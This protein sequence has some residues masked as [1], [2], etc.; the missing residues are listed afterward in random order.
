M[1]KP[2]SAKR[3][4]LTACVLSAIALPAA[5]YACGAVKLAIE[6][7]GPSSARPGDT[8]TY[9]FKVS[10]KLSGT[11]VN[12]FINDD[13]H[14][15]LEYVSSQITGA[16]TR[17]HCEMYNSG[18]T[19][20]LFRCYLGNMGSGHKNVTVTASFKIP[21]TL[22]CVTIKNKA[23]VTAIE[24]V[25]TSNEISTAIECGQPTLSIQKSGQ[26]VITRGDTIS[27]TLNISNTGNANAQ[28]VT[29][30]DPIPSGVTFVSASTDAFSSCST[31]SPNVVCNLGTLAPNQSR[32]I[33][34]I[35]STSDVGACTPTTVI[36]QAR[37]SGSN[38]NTP[39]TAPVTVHSNTVTTQVNCREIPKGCIDVVKQALDSNSNPVT[40]IPSFT[41]T[42]DGSRT[43]S[44]NQTGNLRFNDVTPGT[45]TVTETPLS[46]WQQQSVNPLNGTVNV[47]SGTQCAQVIFQNKQ[48][49]PPV[50]CI[51]VIK[52]VFDANGTQ[53]TNVP[54]FTFTLDGTTTGV[55]DGNGNLR[56]NNVTPALHTVTETLPAGWTQEIVLP[57]QGKVNVQSG[58]QCAQVIFRNKQTPPQTGCIEVRKHAYDPQEV[59]ITAV[60]AFT[61]TLDGTR[62]GA[63]NASGILTFNNVSV[64]QHTVSE[65]VLP[66][67]MIAG[68]TPANGQVTVQA[69]S[70][71]AIVD[72]INKQL[73]AQTGCIEITKSAKDANDNSI[74]SVPPFVF[75]LDGT[76]TATNDTT[77]RTRFDNVSVGS[78]SVI[79]ALPAGWTLQSVTPA[80]GAVTVAAG[81]QCAQVSFVNKQVPAQTG[82]IEITKQAVSANGNN[83]TPIPAFTFK[84]DNNATVTSAADGRARFNSVSVGSHVV[85]EVNL[86]GW[87]LETV[88]PANGQVNVQ[89][90]NNCAQV[91]FR[92]R[93]SAQ[94]VDFSISKTDNET[95]VEPG[96]E[97]TYEITVRNNGS[98]AVSNVTVTDELPDEVDFISASQNGQRNSRTIT[99]NGLTFAAFETKILSVNVE[100]DEDADCDTIRNRATVFDKSATDETDIE[101]CDDDE[102]AEIEITKESSTSEV[103]A[104]GIIEYTV[105]LKNTGEGELE[106]IEVTDHLP[107]GVIVIDDGDA[108]EHDD[109]M[110]MWE[111]DSLDED[112]TWTVTYRVNV[113]VNIQPGSLLRNEVCVEHD[114]MDDD[115]EE[116]KMTTVSVIGNLP[117][118]GYRSRGVNQNLRPVQ[119]K[120]SMN[121]PLVSFVSMIGILTGI[122]AAKSS[123]KRNF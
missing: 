3:M 31:Q 65:T 85:S 117:Q 24:G 74:A 116:C 26:T 71:C 49:P 21:S 23:I 52:Q 66:G 13:I 62:T 29:V 101:E 40:Q 30:T 57:A 112:D 55:N 46:G 47:Q 118:T 2:N 39:G 79:E 56:F 95:E 42:L 43:G 58:N 104:G 70:S 99:W 25:A 63:N 5:G 4:I 78:H 75:T 53:L 33:T 34:L 92:N 83:V 59:R 115:D 18:S 48:T 106:N 45:H 54:Q 17:A 100:V 120:E 12:V 8:I 36:N 50:G 110:L 109:D 84:L 121:L 19:G 86:Q 111:I 119:P 37:V 11:A 9:T 90:G 94:A 105:R 69:G 91:T 14:P 6:K 15:S 68:V 22:Q 1:Y 122:G 93:Q 87:T 113:D 35:F 38:V 32:S 76:R 103:F 51:D 77:G 107:E 72:F 41:F 123:K 64:G 61:F 27:Y 89:S 82:C 97:L 44:S 114:Q 60:P 88:S 108:D 80:N 7:L 28:N 16:E 67:W 73:P 102:E 20:K 81:N 96:D 10:Q 98:Q